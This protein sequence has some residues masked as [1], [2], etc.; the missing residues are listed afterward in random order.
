MLNN[1]YDKYI[2]TGAL[3]YQHHNFYLMGIPFVIAPLEVLLH[4]KLANDHEFNKKL[5]YSVREG[6]LKS[7]KSEFG[8]DFS[9]EGQQGLSLLEAYF[10]ASGF[11]QV[12]QFD[13][14][15]ETSRA[16]MIVNNSPFAFALK[17]KTQSPVDHYLRGT[18]A[19]IFS[20]FFGKKVDCVETECAA[21]SAQRC[22]FIVKQNHELDF[23]NALVRQQV[24]AEE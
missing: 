20:A 21:L 13:R 9:L 10:S 16:I 22:R 14:D 3:K 24:D 2:F 12:S 15:N 18:F 7:V 23:S 17:G 4:E 5:Y 8:V 6:M 11:G 19:G 1:F